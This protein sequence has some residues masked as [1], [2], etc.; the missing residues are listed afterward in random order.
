MLAN[1]ELLH[2]RQV[3]RV[4]APSS[5]RRDPRH[6]LPGVAASPHQGLRTSAAAGLARTWRG[7]VGTSRQIEPVRSQLMRSRAR[8][9][10]SL[11]P[12]WT[13][14]FSDL[15]RGVGLEPTTY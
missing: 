5:Q 6:A 15:A 14:E 1:E 9:T 11:D 4:S 10:P 2:R 8:A 13:P 3:R 7:V 12:V